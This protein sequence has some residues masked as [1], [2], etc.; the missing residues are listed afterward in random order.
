MSEHHDSKLQKGIS[1]RAF[2]LAGLG[3]VAAL[4]ALKAAPA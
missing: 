4:V 3:S 1:R 2:N